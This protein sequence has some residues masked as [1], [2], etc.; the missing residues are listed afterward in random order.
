M[1]QKM[2]V[3]FEVGSRVE[4]FYGDAWYSGVVIALPD[5]NAE[6]MAK[7]G[8]WTV[9]CD[10]DPKGTLTPAERIRQVGGGCEVHC[11]APQDAS[12]PSQHH[13]QLQP[14]PVWHEKVRP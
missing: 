8:R 7:R 11:S 14:Q 3:D 13:P 6:D 9:Q 10:V 4:A 1:P 2:E 12:A 5:E